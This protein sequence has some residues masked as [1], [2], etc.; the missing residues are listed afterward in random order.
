MSS[1]LVDSVAIVGFGL[2]GAS[3]AA[4]L[5]RNV[6]GIRLLAVDVSAVV[7]DPLARERV[8]ELVSI[9][10]TSAWQAIVASTALTVL[11]GPVSTI[12]RQLPDMLA[13]ANVLTDCGSTKRRIAGVARDQPRREQ[14]VPG[15]PMAGKT[16]SG[17]A[18]ASADLF[19]GKPWIVCPDGC[20]SAAL[21]TVHSMVRAV[22]AEPVEMAAERHDE[23]VALTSHLPKLLAAVLV[24][25]CHEAGAEPARGPAFHR[26]TRVAQGDVGIWRDIFASNADAVARSID[27]LREELGGLADALRADDIE[28][29]MEALERARRIK[30]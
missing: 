12:E 29:T 15:H 3:L 8:D 11:A 14:F 7:R 24:Q 13:I 30:G 22:G 18:A 9:D 20:G 5:R 17:W 4:A 25:L 6:P 10:D 1:P 26:A 28:V 21:Q 2:I 16:E 23:A 27:R 19:T